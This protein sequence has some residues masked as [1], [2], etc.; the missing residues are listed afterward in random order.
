MFDSI[1]DAATRLA[2]ARY[3]TGRD[4]A[5]TVF[6]A[7]KVGKPV[8]VEGEPGSGKSALAN[9]VARALG[10]QLIRLQCFEGIYERAAVSDWSLARQL[11][12]S[13][14][15]E[16]AG[17]SRADVERELW[18][19][20]YLVKRPIL[21]AI[22]GDSAKSSV[23]LIDDADRADDRFIA[24]LSDFLLSFEV[25]VPELGIVRASQRPLVFITSGRDRELGEALRRR[26]LYQWL[27][28]PGFEREH[29]IVA[30]HVPAL[31][32][33]L[34]GQVCNFIQRVRGAGFSRPPGIA[35]TLDW[36]RA[37]AALRASGLDAQLVDQTLG[38]ILKRPDDIERFRS[39][40]FFES[41]QPG[42]DRAG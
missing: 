32:G 19:E 27:D 11:L 18:S 36:A 33:P 35:E 12:R 26:C 20:D 2:A 23:L 39:A 29:E 21:E 4:V 13:H 34:I 25:V 17:E 24:F 31:P 28:Y 3:V 42:L 37:L 16:Q 15:A 30:I 41:Q 9:A 1:D 7:A 14:E 6:L 40:R 5:T 8:L 10:A 22:T 38:C